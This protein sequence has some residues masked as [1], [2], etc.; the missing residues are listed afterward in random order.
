MGRIVI[1]GYKPKPGKEQELEL[2]VLN[3]MQILRSQRLVTA[4]ESILMR[5]NTGTI[6]EVFEWK[7]K[8]AMESA[9]ENEVILE[10]WEQYAEVCDYIPVA[11]I[12][13]ISTLFSEFS[14][15]H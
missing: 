13:E 8:A 7:S 9:H 5:S 11:E 4:R 10:M 1:V 2:L 14:P 12:P 15:L 6:I 3:H